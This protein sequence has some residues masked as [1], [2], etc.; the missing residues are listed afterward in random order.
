[1]G[2]THDKSDLKLESTISFH[3][4][5]WLFCVAQAGHD[6]SKNESCKVYK[7]LFGRAKPFLEMGLGQVVDTVLP[8]GQIGDADGALRKEFY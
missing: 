8:Q 1:M 4:E 7:Q 6:S 3:V 5:K 2:K